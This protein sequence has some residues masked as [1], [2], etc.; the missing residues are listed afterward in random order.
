M[1]EK[2]YIIALKKHKSKKNNYNLSNIL[3]KLHFST[4]L[5]FFLFFK[6]IANIDYQI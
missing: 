2:I 1:A 3:L 5:F 6:N 4:I